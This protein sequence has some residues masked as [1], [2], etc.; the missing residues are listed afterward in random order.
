MISS[1]L[2]TNTLETDILPGSKTD[3]FLITLFLGT[4]TN[5]RGPGFWKLNSHFLKVLEYINLIRETL[6]VVSNDY[7]EYESVYA[8]LLWDVI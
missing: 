7:K 8:T 4:K 2:S 5:P 6:N 3:H 1:S